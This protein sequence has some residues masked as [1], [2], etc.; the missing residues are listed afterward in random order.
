MRPPVS[1]R[2]QYSSPSATRKKSALFEAISSQVPSTPHPALG[3]RGCDE[4]SGATPQTRSGVGRGADV[5][6]PVDW[7]RVAARRGQWPPKKVLVQ[8]GGAAVRVAVDGIG[9]ATAQV[10]RRQDV[11]PEDFVAQIGGVAGEPVQHAVGIASG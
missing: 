10:V 7:G 8:L 11:N 2:I 3:Q 9:V 4:M 1:Q 5:P 6:E